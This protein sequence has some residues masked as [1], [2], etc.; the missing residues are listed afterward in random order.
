MIDR[1][2]REVNYLRLSLTSRCN[3]RCNYCLPADLIQSGPEALGEDDF[4][5]I[6]EAAARAGI[7]RVRLTGGEPMLVPFLPA[8]VSRIAAIDGIEDIALTTNG[9]SLA[10]N[11]STLKQAGLTRVNISIDSL[12]PDRYREIT[13]GGNLETVLSGVWAALRAE[14][15]PVKINCVVIG[16]VNDDE[17][18]D[19]VALTLHHPLSVRFIELMPFGECSDWPEARFIPMEQVIKS[20]G[21]LE[22]AATEGG[23]PAAIYRVPGAMGTVGFIQGVS[24]HF[25]ATCNRLRITSQG[26]IRPCLFAD[27]ELDMIAAIRARDIEMAGQMMRDALEHK[28]DRMAVQRR[29][30]MAE[31][32]G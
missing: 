13:R 26:K 5:F 27:D 15:C 22:P 20:I 28:P 21:A 23:G 12:K 19:Y 9:V 7:Q 29:K 17:I 25:C 31:I 11:A 32:G 30:K 10:E 6:V 8:L 18:A 16:G 2:G 14:L 3:L 24:R 4:V 1:L